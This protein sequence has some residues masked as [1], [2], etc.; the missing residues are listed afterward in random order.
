MAHLGKLETQLELPLPLPQPPHFSMAHMFLMQ[1]E[2]GE[3]IALSFGPVCVNR[4]RVVTWRVSGVGVGGWGHGELETRGE[5]G[6][7]SAASLSP[8]WS[9]S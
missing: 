7:K 2:S 3:K 9:V 4:G 5:G 6:E 8:I 1:S